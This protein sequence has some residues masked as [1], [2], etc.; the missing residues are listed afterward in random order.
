MIAAVAAMPG[1]GTRREAIMIVRLI[2]IEL[3]AVSL[4]GHG[5]TRSL[6]KATTRVRHERAMHA[7]VGHVTMKVGSVHRVLHRCSLFNAGE[8]RS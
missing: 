8:P 5:T 4:T 2:S 3:H 7:P 6:R 1:H